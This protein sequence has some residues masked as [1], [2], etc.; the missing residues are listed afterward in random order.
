VLSKRAP[1]SCT[2]RS[3]EA[4]S[5]DV[6]R[7]LSR[8]QIA[9]NSSGLSAMFLSERMNATWSPTSTFEGNRV[10]KRDRRENATTDDNMD[11]GTPR[12]DSSAL[13]WR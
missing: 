5:D 12:Y 7:T 2:C 8:E 3:K 4:V 10:M 9:S 11:R 6:S 1:R 13:M